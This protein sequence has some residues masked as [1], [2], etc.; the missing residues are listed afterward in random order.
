MVICAVI[1]TVF[2]KPCKMGQTSTIHTCLVNESQYETTCYFK[3]LDENPEDK[4]SFQLLQS[5]TEKRLAIIPPYGMLPLTFTFK[6]LQIGI[7]AQT[8][9]L[10]MVSPSVRTLPGAMRNKE[11][12]F[13]GICIP[14]R[15]ALPDEVLHPTIDRLIFWLSQN[16]SLRNTVSDVGIE[17]V[18]TGIIETSPLDAYDV[19]FK[20][21]A[22]VPSVAGDFSTIPQVLATQNRGNLVRKVRFFGSPGFT[23]DPKF[24]VVAPGETVALEP[25]FQPP[26]SV[27]NLVTIF[28]FAVV[29]DQGESRMN[30]TQII[31]KLNQGFMLL[32][33]ENH[34]EQQIVF[35]FGRV[36]ST[37]EANS[38]C[39]RY[40]MLCN[41]FNSRYQWSIK[42][43][44]LA[45]KT[46]SFDIPLLKGE[47]GRME[48][49]AVPFKLKKEISGV[50]ET[51][52]EVLIDPVDPAGKSV[53]LGTIILKGVISYTMLLGIPDSIEF[54]STIVDHTT[55]KK[56]VLQNEGTQEMD[57]TILLRPPFHVNL[58]KF[59][60]PAK[61]S[62]SII[63]SFSPTEHQ[64]AKNTFQV[65]ANQKLISVE[66]SGTGGIAALVCEK[67]MDNP[68]DFGLQQDGMMAFAE[69]Y[70]TNSGTIPLKLTSILS[71]TP[72]LLRLEYLGSTLNSSKLEYLPI[73]RK[74]FWKSVKRKIK[75]SQ[76]IFNEKTSTNSKR[77]PI[78]APAFKENLQR[79]LIEIGELGVVSPL[80]LTVQIPELAPLSSYIFRI[81]YPVS[82]FD[83]SDREINFSYLPISDDGDSSL[84][85][86]L[87]KSM[88]IEVTARSFQPLEILPYSLN[89]GYYPAES[90]QE[91]ESSKYNHST[92]LAY[93]VTVRKS[94][95]SSP[96]MFLKLINK[97]Y[98]GQTITLE[99]ISP[100]FVISG[101]TT[102]QVPA[103]T[104]IEVAVEF[105]PPL[106]QRRYV[107]SAIFAHRHGTI[108]VT[109]IGTG[110][111]AELVCSETVDFGTL[112]LDIAGTKAFVMHNRGIL[113]CQYEMDIVQNSNEFAL[114]DGDSFETEGFISSGETVSKIIDCRCQNKIGATGQIVVRW[115]KVPNGRTEVAIVPLK[116][117]IGYPEFRIHTS[118]LDFA[119]TYIGINKVVVLHVHNDGNAACNWQVQSDN[120]DLT[121][122]VNSGV[123]PPGATASIN[124][125]YTP[126][127]YE[128]LDTSISFNTDSG[129]YRVACFGVVGVP[130]LK[131]M[132]E[133]R[134][135]DFGLLTIGKQHHVFLDMANS[136]QNAIEYDVEWTQMSK[137]S[138]AC[139]HDEF[140]YFFAE[141]SHGI[142]ASGDLFSLK[143]VV[144]PKDYKVIYEGTFMIRALTGEQHHLKVRAIGGQAIIKIR[145]TH[146]P[147]LV[148]TSS[149]NR[150]GSSNRLNV[151]PASTE[152]ARKP[153]SVFP[154][155]QANSANEQKSKTGAPTLPAQNTTKFL[156]KAHLDNLYEVLGGFRAAQIEI[157]NSIS[158]EIDVKSLFPR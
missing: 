156:M 81:G 14:V 111:S 18:T 19:A 36:E 4:T 96:S 9:S 130:Y 129:F 86:V 93:G 70:L 126:K 106:E 143:L 62:Q 115:K 101:V 102:W 49:F 11:L 22:Y 33:F 125:K 69:V 25:Y 123:I 46:L 35:D 142:I 71:P 103:M 50:Y 45:R 5:Y 52:C 122:E 15:K 26:P 97:S 141:P 92:D 104:T 42:V 139:S 107:G 7:A 138:V 84:N 117:L 124:V 77:Y 61:S 47:I 158:P 146:R 88:T 23:I 37:G 98:N 76:F 54:G 80:N 65:F 148:P 72:E 31:R 100:E 16:K 59:M 109:L 105:H 110:A 60:I 144:C 79:K 95:A 89:F 21:E 128:I 68:L 57:V 127:D 48:T 1:T 51:K 73:L 85:E 113:G 43:S 8:I 34:T 17:E 108:C 133:E 87:L 118:A 58:Q 150:L 44:P 66:I 29:L 157:S 12:S 3:G 136:G 74:D 145:P 41:P 154:P 155:S 27:G 91:K 94:H 116:L 28:G 13:F 137:D 135:I 134:F 147:A 6:P 40:L 39:T 10:E 78:K 30:A 120:P 63:V 152:K 149:A 140:A 132:N 121:T 56:L 55:K 112:R 119:T 67:Y 24:K 83:E 38:E 151:A 20:T 153:S 75:A 32:P 99:K 2:F 53:R 131:I 82:S 64:R 114:K 90:F